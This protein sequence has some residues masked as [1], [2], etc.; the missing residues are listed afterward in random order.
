MINFEGKK[1][2]FKLAFKYD[3]LFIYRFSKVNLLQT[4]G[5]LTF[6]QVKEGLAPPVLVEDYNDAILYFE[7][8]LSLL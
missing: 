4:I 3:R 7:K 1:Y 2:N 5:G 6:Q 8:Y